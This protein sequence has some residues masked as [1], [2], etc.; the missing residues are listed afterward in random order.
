M[1]AIPWLRSL[2]HTHIHSL[3]L[4]DSLRWLQQNPL[5]KVDK[6]Q[7]LPLPTLFVPLPFLVRITLTRLYCLGR[8][9]ALPLDLGNIRYVA[10]LASP[11][12]QLYL[13]FAYHA[14]YPIFPLQLN[15]FLFIEPCRNLSRSSLP[16]VLFPYIQEVR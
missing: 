10:R 16:R 8:D 14:T 13:Q 15:L 11:G 7:H 5:K 1:P 4:C 9:A 3:Y 2:S 6:A 12:P